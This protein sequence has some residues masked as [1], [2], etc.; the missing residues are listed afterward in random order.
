M[1]IK[2][3]IT[4]IEESINQTRIFYDETYAE[5]KKHCEFGCAF[6]AAVRRRE[7]ELKEEKSKSIAGVPGDQVLAF[8]ESFKRSDKIDS[9]FKNKKDIFDKYGAIDPKAYA[10]L[11]QHG[12]SDSQIR[13]HFNITNNRWQK[14]KKTYFPADSEQ[15]KKLGV[16]AM[17]E[18]KSSHVFGNNQH[19]H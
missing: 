14:F 18:F 9:L 10:L 7:N 13:E 5:H 11:K 1:W 6:C 17:K 8:R 15:A 4:S 12:L 3:P 2:N 16:E 19:L